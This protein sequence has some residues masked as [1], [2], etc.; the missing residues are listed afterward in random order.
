[1]MPLSRLNFVNDICFAN[2]SVFESGSGHRRIGRRG[3]AGIP[4]GLPPRFGP[5]TVEA[6]GTVCPGSG[7]SGGNGNCVVTARQPGNDSYNAA[8]NVAQTITVDSLVSEKSCWR[9]ISSGC[10]M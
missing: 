5:G 7:V 2:S 6:A 8:P 10:P 3:A 9:S 4:S 1:M